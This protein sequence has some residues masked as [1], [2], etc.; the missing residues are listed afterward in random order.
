MS[1]S[2]DIERE[3]YKTDE[4]LLDEF[5]ELLPLLTQCSRLISDARDRV[6][7][8][9]DT[10]DGAISLHS[11][12]DALV[13]GSLTENDIEWYMKYSR[14]ALSSTRDAIFD[15]DD[16][17]ETLEQLIKRL[18]DLEGALDDLYPPK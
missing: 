6:L 18:D 17:A 14:N 12:R 10:V 7:V 5:N 16:A 9:R 13:K 15:V 8:Q 2:Q 3:A 1:E 11:H 4:A